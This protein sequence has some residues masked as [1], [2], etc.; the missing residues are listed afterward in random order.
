MYAGIERLSG[1]RHEFCESRFVHE[2]QFGELEARGK[3][4]PDDGVDAF[5]DKFRGVV[6]VVDDVRLVSL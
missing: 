6:E 2:V 5:D 3:L 4:R 1:V